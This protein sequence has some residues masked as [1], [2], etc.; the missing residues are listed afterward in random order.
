MAVQNHKYELRVDTGGE[1]I[2]DG[3]KLVAAAAT[4]ERL[5]ASATKCKS[6]TITAKMTNT[7]VICVGGST[8][9]AASGANRTGIPLNPGDSVTLD[10]DDL[11]KVFVDATVSGEGV[12][13][14]ALN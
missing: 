10:I 3:K 7:G 6:V 5:A 14:V 9:V 2:T 1:A 4:A 11:Y 8:V 13:F 12:T